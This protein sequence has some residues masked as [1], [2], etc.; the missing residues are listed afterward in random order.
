[1][2]T[3]FLKDTFGTRSLVPWALAGGGAYFVWYRP[4][5]QKKEEEAARA[6]N[7]ERLMKEAK[8]VDFV[9]NHIAQAT[10]KKGGGWFG[11][12]FGGGGG[13]T[14]EKTENSGKK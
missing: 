8:Y 1:M 14:P 9:E 12:W 2:A 6:T 3:K 5:Q 4:E 13:S 7:A 11:G 10:K